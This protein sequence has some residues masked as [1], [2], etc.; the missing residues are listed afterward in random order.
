[1]TIAIP[2]LAGLTGVPDHCTGYRADCPTNDRTLYRIAG[3]CGTDCG[4]TQAANGS[5]LFG[6]GTCRERN[7]QA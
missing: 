3:H 4:P 6:T 1:M 7:E 2:A 5:A